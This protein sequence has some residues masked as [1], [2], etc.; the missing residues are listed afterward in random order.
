MHRTYPELDFA[1]LSKKMGEIWHQ[2]PQ[3]EKA[4]WFSK[5][6][7]IAEHG[8]SIVNDPTNE[9]DSIYKLDHLDESMIPKVITDRTTMPITIDTVNL[10][11]ENFPAAIGDNDDVG[12]FEGDQHKIGLEFADL[13]A[14]LHILGDSL[15]SIGSYLSRGVRYNSDIEYRPEAAMSTLLDTALVACASLTVL[16]N[17]VPALQ[18]DQARMKRLM[19]GVT[20][21]MPP[22]DQ[23]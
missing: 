5:A 6:K 13:E 18:M 16:A 20:Y 19:D 3:N 9:C 2:L 23:S 14:Y 21:F 17:K 7:M 1:S 12:V 11:E 22:N 15:M 4:T 8:P 10:F